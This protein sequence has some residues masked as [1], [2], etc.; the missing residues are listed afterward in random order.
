ML[1]K[2]LK[3]DDDV[4]GV[5][6]NARWSD[7]GK[8]MTLAV[9]LERSLYEKV[10]KALTAL[11]GKWNRGK[12]AHLFPLDP[13]GKVDG[14]LSSGTLSV[15][16]EG[17]FE[18]P[19]ELVEKIIELAEIKPEHSV[20]EPSAGL[21]AIANLLPE[22]YLD[23]CE[24]NPERAE[25]LIASGLCF[26]AYDFMEYRQGDYDRIVMNPPFEQRQDADHILHAFDLL[27][28]GGR[29]VSICSEGLFFGQDEKAKKFREWLDKYGYDENLP[30]GTFKSSG[31]EVNTRLVVANKP[32]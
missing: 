29:L 8:S 16:K 27:A 30:N 24:K 15:A 28:P 4:I 9:Q 5:L 21:G 26:Q 31:T 22:C 17:F 13:R 12:K 23:V 20:L 32:A 11:G 3:F 19:K 7:D 2:T 25:H 1:T 18:T 10:N 6:A 14:L